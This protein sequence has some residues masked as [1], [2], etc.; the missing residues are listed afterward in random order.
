MPVA[1]LKEELAG[2]PDWVLCGGYSVALITGADTRA[3]GDIDIGVFRSQLKDCLNALGRDRVQL[4]HYG[5]HEAWAGGEV[6]AEVHDIWITDRARRYWVLQVMVF[7]DEGGRV[8][9]RR[10]QR[11]SW[12]KKDHA[13]EVGGI[14][15]LNPLITVLF[16][17][18]KANM[19]DKEAHDIMELIADAAKR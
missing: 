6:P 17:A 4:C 9:Y 15:V 5:A 12:A 13:I 7:D 2:F 19:A 1:A 3:H 11:I 10:D 18:N 16:K 8:I 14:R